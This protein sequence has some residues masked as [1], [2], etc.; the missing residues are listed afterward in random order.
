[1]T[2]PPD[3]F[4]EALWALH[5]AEKAAKRSAPERPA[6]AVVLDGDVTTIT[7][8]A[9]YAE[10][11]LGTARRDLEALV[12]GERNNGLNTVAFALGR[13]VGGDLLEH[14]FVEQW[15]EEAAEIWPDR[16]VNNVL[17][18]IRSGMAAGEASPIIW[19]HGER[20]AASDDPFGFSG[21]PARIL[22]AVSTGEP[23]RSTG[24]LP[25]DLTP[26][27]DGSY[28][29]VLP[30]LLKR[31]DGVPGIYAGRVHWLSGEPESLKTWLALLACQQALQL[32]EH[33]VYIDLEDSP[34]GMV[35]R[36]QAMGL[37]NDVIA[38]RFHYI[39]PDGPL[40]ADAR[41]AIEYVVRGA[42]LLIIDAATEALS[43]QGLTPKDD[44]DV[45]AWL[46]MLPRWA[47]KLGPAVVVLDH[48]VKDAETRGRW[49]TGS[50]HKL[51]GLDGVAYIVEPVTPGGRGK[52]GRSRVFVAKDRHGHLGPHVVMVKG[53]K[54]WFADLVVADNGIFLEVV[55]H[56]AT[57]ENVEDAE[58][59]TQLMRKISQ[60][61]AG[62]TKPLNVGD[63]RDR[64]KGN[65]SDCNFALAKLI[66][67]GF[68]V[69]EQ[70]KGNAKIN[71]LVKPFHDVEDAAA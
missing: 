55:L 15:L 26:Y 65:A 51:A 28:K 4:G 46:E 12:Y 25:T 41:A 60:V 59:P 56:P 18:T 45:A 39:S 6:G 13:L 69:Q 71:T 40:T 24:W 35:G 50:Q 66:D 54:R 11:A 52:T 7:D 21:S 16:D 5:D 37:P 9:R 53:G 22:E 48:V 42:A 32:D 43:R 29:P 62:A 36:L 3:P 33:V 31:T 49:A 44:V 58:M 67:S 61:L 57:Q 64:V 19:V 27:L 20:Q 14:D 10:T 23:V 47:V 8:P 2:G 1:M 17:G 34:Q 70:G 63:V 68:V 38:E 30:S